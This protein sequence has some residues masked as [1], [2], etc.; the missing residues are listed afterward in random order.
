MSEHQQDLYYIMSDGLDCRPYKRSS[1]LT[2]SA[3][4]VTVPGK[5]RHKPAYGGVHQCLGLR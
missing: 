1:L 4:N 5:R 2:G 3:A